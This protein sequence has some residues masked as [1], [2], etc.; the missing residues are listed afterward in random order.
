M[1]DRI[2]CMKNVLLFFSFFPNVIQPPFIIIGNAV[3]EFLVYIR[4]CKK[5]IRK[6]NMASSSSITVNIP[7]IESHDAERRRYLSYFFFVILLKFLLLY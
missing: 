3:F 6:Y 7:G 4:I 2:L 5:P 1:Y